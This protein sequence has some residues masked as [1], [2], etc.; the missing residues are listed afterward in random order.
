MIT[1]MTLLL[2]ATA[3]LVLVPL[4]AVLNLVRHDRPAVAPLSQRDWSSG[5]MPSLPYSSPYVL[6]H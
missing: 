3:L 4:V 2:V 1:A 6:R 5:P